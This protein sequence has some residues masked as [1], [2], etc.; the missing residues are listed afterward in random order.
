[1][2]AAWREAI[3]ALAFRPAGHDGWC[4]VHRRA[5]GTVIGRGAGREACLAWFAEH[6]DLFE[7]AARAKIDRAGLPRG[8]NFH[9]TSRDLKRASTTAAGAA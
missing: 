9:L 6:A 2:T 3:D 7:R 1:M 5:L 4:V 8:A